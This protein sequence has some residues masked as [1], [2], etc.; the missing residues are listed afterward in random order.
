MHRLYFYVDESGQDTQ[1]QPG[2]VVIF[3][4]TVVVAFEN[5]EELERLCIRYER[6]SS[7][8]SKWSKSKREHRYQFVKLIF[9]DRRFRETLRFTVY[10]PTEAEPVIDYDHATIIAIWKA[11]EISASRLGFDSGEYTADVFVDGIS[12][13]QQKTYKH[14]LSRLRCNVRR[15]HRARDESY[16]FIRLAD[17]LAGFVREAAEGDEEARRLLIQGRRNGIVLEIETDKKSTH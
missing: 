8:T 15:V 13:A 12:K 10:G 5:F 2:R 11:V 7:K 4:V 16:A 14:Q 9:N 17:A 6:E 3:V 1:A